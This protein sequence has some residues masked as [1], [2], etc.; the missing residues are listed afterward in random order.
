MQF[1]RKTIRNLNACD[2]SFFGESRS[3]RFWYLGNDASILISGR[4]RQHWSGAVIGISFC[5]SSPSYQE[6]KELGVDRNQRRGQKRPDQSNNRSTSILDRAK[7]GAKAIRHTKQ[8]QKQGSFK[9]KRCV[10]GFQHPIYIILFHWIST[11]LLVFLNFHV[12]VDD[13]SKF[14]I[15]RKWT[16]KLLKWKV[17]R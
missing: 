11:A 12:N 2:S 3:R 5:F 16:S 14:W 1:S 17:D 9:G 15:D 13:T 7:K 6:R 4:W 8:G 10:A